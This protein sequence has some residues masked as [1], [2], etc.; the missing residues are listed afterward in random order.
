MK[1]GMTGTG[2]KGWRDG[3]AVKKSASLLNGPAGNREAFFSVLCVMFLV[4]C[5]VV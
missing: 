5:C 1:S 2:R 3:K 4:L